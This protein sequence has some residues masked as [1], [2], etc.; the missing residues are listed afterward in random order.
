M[1]KIKEYLIAPIIV[2]LICLVVFLLKG[3]YPFGNQTIASG[4][5]GQS[6]IPFYYFLYDVFH[7]TKSIFFDYALGLGSNTYGGFVVDGLFNPTSWII[8]LSSRSNIPYMLS[9][10]MI[11]KLMFIA[12][13]SYILFKKINPKHQFYNILFSIMYALSSYCLIYNSNI[14]WLDVVG[15]FP[16]FILATKHLLIDGKIY[17]FGIVLALILLFNYN[18]AFMVLLFIIFIIPIYI[19]YGL[20]KEKR[21]KAVFNLIMGVLISIGLSA[22]AFIPAL[23][24]TLTSYRFSGSITNSVANEYFPHKLLIFF[25]YALPLLLYIYAHTNKSTNK[26]NLKM[27]DISLLMTAVIPILF[28]RVNLMWHTGSYQEFPFRYGFIPL[29]LLYIGS[30]EYCKV[31]KEV[32]KK[33]QSINYKSLIIAIILMIIVSSALIYNAIYI[34]NHNPVFNYNDFRS[35]IIIIVSTALSIHIYNLLLKMEYKKLTYP[36]MGIFTIICATCFTYGYLGIN[37]NN[38]V[39]NEHSDKPI[40]YSEKL[41]EKVNSNLYRIKNET[42]KEFENNALISNIPDQKSFVHIIGKNQIFNNKQL[43]YSAYKTKLQGAGGTIFTDAIVGTKYVV[44]SNKLSNDIYHKID[45]IGNDNIYEYNNVLPYGI[46]YDKEIKKIPEDK[47]IFDANNYLYK[48]LFNKKDNLIDIKKISVNKKDKTKEITFSIKEEKELYLYIDDFDVEDNTDNIIA[49]QIEVNNKTINIPRVNKENSTIYPTAE[50]NGIID[51]GTFKNEDV[52]VKISFAKLNY[53]FD[54]NEIIF[55]LLDINKYLDIFNYKHNIDVSTEKNKI[56]IKGNVDKNTNILLPIVY[57]KGFTSNVE[58]KEVYNT[59]IGVPLTKGKN[60]IVITFYP[61]M[62]KESLLLTIA[63]IVIMILCH[64]IKRKFDI[65]NINF[66]TFIFWLFGILVL[67]LAL[68]KVY[69][70][71]IIDTFLDMI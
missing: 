30:L 19:H 43:G 13:T 49:F 15:L 1:K 25:F 52:T 62:F 53:T 58:L 44:S 27:I 5:F 35:F 41:G 54:K 29:L 47:K 59:F 37:K 57:D 26:N 14:M 70:K 50:R 46:L 33:K 24:Q 7:G 60:N 8:L 67:I 10:V 42:M 61:K 31:I 45:N 11:L 17:Y 23:V 38:W 36:I 9:F 21:K 71:C 16:L 51:L 63:T 12:L 64:F 20:E 39:E 2:L 55:G 65:R 68:Y 6:Y 18:L 3:I 69:I 40:F 66:I 4:D 22:F 34:N 28:E 32:K 48:N 56:Y